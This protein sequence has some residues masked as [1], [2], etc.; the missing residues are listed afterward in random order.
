M[1]FELKELHTLFM[2]FYHEFD[3]DQNLTFDFEETM[4]CFEAFA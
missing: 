1:A 4:A 2:K 3:S